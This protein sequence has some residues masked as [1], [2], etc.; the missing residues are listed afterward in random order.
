M[1]PHDISE[2]ELLSSASDCI[3]VNVQTCKPKLTIVGSWML[4]QDVINRSDSS[5]VDV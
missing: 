4:N 5:E 1:F 2:R 3:S